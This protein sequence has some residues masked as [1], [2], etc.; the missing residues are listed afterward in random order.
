MSDAVK[1]AGI[2]SRDTIYAG[3][4]RFDAMVH[5]SRTEGFGLIVAEAMSAGLPLVLTAHDGPWEVADHGRL[6][7]SGRN[8]DAE[9]FADAIAQLID[10]Y[11]AAL[12]RA[13]EAKEYVKRFDIGHTV[14]NYRRIYRQDK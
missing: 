7:L 14:D 1:F 2:Q 4:C 9:S 10:N 11:P 6:C 3:L 8:G 13:K 12:E 5:P